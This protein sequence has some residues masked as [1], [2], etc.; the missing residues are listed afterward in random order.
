MEPAYSLITT[1]ADYRHACDVVIARAQYEILIF[2][3]DLSAPRL[4]EKSR[5]DLLT[6]F[7]AAEGLRHLRIVLHEPEILRS[8]A[9]R[10][11]QLFTRFSHLIEIRQSPDNLRHLADTHQV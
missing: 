1:E 10:L 3:R 6:R 2:D 4:D 11:M 7:L 5:I 9:P 8:R